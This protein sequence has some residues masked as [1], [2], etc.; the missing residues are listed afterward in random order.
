[1][2]MFL[3]PIRMQ[4][5]SLS[6]RRTNQNS[7]T[8]FLD[9]LSFGWF[10]EHSANG[11]A[12]LL[13]IEKCSFKVMSF[14]LFLFQ[15]HMKTALL[16]VAMI[17]LVFQLLPTVFELKAMELVLH[18]ASFKGPKDVQLVFE[19]LKVRIECYYQDSLVMN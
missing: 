5:R 19:A 8:E 15:G 17:F 4:V 10:C 11:L 6:V 13:D 9:F 3:Y 14:H 12:F 7:R 16:Q 2:N 18:H 1:M